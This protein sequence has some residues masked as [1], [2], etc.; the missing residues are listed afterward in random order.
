MRIPSIADEPNEYLWSEN[1][2]EALSG[3]DIIISCGTLP[4]EQITLLEEIP[5]RDAILRQ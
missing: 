5:Y 4:G 3:I 2:R 1:V